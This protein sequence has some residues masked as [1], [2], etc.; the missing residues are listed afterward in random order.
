MITV[1]FT[2]LIT[3][4]PDLSVMVIKTAFTPTSESVNTF[5]L[6]TIVS[7]EQLSELDKTTIDCFK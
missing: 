2:D 6:N 1:T 7:T 3:V 5:L 4:F